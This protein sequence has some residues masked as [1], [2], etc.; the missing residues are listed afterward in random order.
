MTKVAGIAHVV[1]RR[2]LTETRAKFVQGERCVRQL[3]RILRKSGVR[4]N[5]THYIESKLCS[6]YFECHMIKFEWYGGKT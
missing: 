4:W 1:E 3:R 2:K 6:D 5:E